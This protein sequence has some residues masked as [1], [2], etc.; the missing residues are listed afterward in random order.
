MDI[1]LEELV[2]PVRVFSPMLEQCAEVCEGALLEASK[3][4]VSK[5]SSERL[6]V[7]GASRNLVVT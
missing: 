1:I 5:D 2:E 3:R 7:A 4:N 6:L